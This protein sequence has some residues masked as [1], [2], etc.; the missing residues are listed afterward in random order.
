MI[1]EIFNCGCCGDKTDADEGIADPQLGMLCQICNYRCIA[2]QKELFG[3]GIKRPVCR[4]DVNEH[5][6]KRFQAPK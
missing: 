6:F 4:D 5:N 1:A 3:H 2:A